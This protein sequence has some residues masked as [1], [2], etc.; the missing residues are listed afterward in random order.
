MRTWPYASWQIFSSLDNDVVRALGKTRVP[1]RQ[2]KTKA[3]KKESLKVKYCD[4]KEGTEQMTERIDLHE[5]SNRICEVNR[6]GDLDVT[7]SE[8][9]N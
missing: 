1:V 4:G 9:W 5:A 2:T 3:K 6:E 7:H 8:R